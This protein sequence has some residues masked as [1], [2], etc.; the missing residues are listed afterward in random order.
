M[1]PI[2]VPVQVEVAL[3]SGGYIV[4]SPIPVR[5][6]DGQSYDEFFIGGRAT[7]TEGQHGVARVE[8]PPSD[9]PRPQAEWINDTKFGDFLLA[10]LR[11]DAGS[12]TDT[13]VDG[14]LTAAINELQSAYQEAEEASARYY[15]RKERELQDLGRAIDAEKQRLDQEQSRLSQTS[16][17][18]DERAKQLRKR[19]E[20]LDSPEARRLEQ[21]LGLRSASTKTIQF[22]PTDIVPEAPLDRTIAKA[23]ELDLRVE[24]CL[25][26]RA[27]IGTLLA[28]L[29]G[30]ILLLGGPPGSGKS[31][32]ADLIAQGL[33]GRRAEMISV[34]PEWLD[35]ADLLGFLLPGQAVYSTTPFLDVLLEG[36]QGTHP[37]RIV[38]LD[39]L[40]IARIE[41]YAADLLGEFERSKDSAGGEEL[42]LY[43]SAQLRHLDAL[44]A[45]RGEDSPEAAALRLLNTHVPE[46]ISLPRSLCLLGTLNDDVTTY[47]LSPKVLD[48]SLGLRVEHDPPLSVFHFGEAT[49][50]SGQAEPQRAS[51]QSDHCPSEGQVAEEIE[52]VWGICTSEHGKSTLEQLGLHPSRRLY[53]ALQAARHVLVHIPAPATATVEDVLLMRLLPAV[54]G[55]PGSTTVTNAAAAFEDWGLTSISGELSR[56]QKRVALRNRPVSWLN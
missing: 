19:E 18:Q 48:R 53:R 13:G 43:S 50:S 14:E 37:T 20:V 33:T 24:A 28:R 39:E 38:V 41:N 1:S 5:L 51:D 26:R 21:I 22:A 42:R 23:A 15:S 46:R 30:Q 6:A 27:V 44:A 29:T 10:R 2:E 7:L 49:E 54:T 25:L 4:K 17:E 12:A 3:K 34:R 16:E 35:A 8:G 52:R 47:E 9:H 36:D 32:L 40:N 11:L 45:T 56:L 55:E 31:T